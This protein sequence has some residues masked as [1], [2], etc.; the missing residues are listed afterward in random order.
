MGAEFSAF[1]FKHKIPATAA[2][3]SIGS[4]SAEMAK[5]M[6]HGLVL[7]LV[8]SAVGLVHP[9][10]NTPKFEIMA[11]ANSIVVWMCVLVTSY[12]L[13]EYLFARGVIGVSTVVLDKEEEET[14]NKARK[15]AGEPIR[16]AREAVKHVVDNISG[17]PSHSSPSDNLLAPISG[18]SGTNAIVPGRRGSEPCPN[19]GDL[20]AG[21]ARTS[22]SGAVARKCAPA[23]FDGSL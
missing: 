19:A 8:F 17:T 13:M 9:L 23:E 2:S 3:F 18:N 6:A 7:P 12:L 21:Q 15:Q 14:I 1:M 4:A 16:R 5:S 22:I 10:K 20:P 11:F